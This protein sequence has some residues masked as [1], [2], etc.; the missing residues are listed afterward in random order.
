MSS[1]QAQHNQF[2]V[3]EFTKQSVPF[4]EAVVHFDD[5]LLDFSEVK[6]ADTVLD[7]A[8]GPGIVA[9]SFATR[10]KHV[11][12]IDLTPAMLE[13]ANKRQEKMQLENLSWQLGDVLPFRLRMR[14]F[15]WS[16]RGTR[17]I[18]FL[19][20]WRCARKCCAFVSRAEP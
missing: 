9:C 19:I 5:L 12:G 1:A 18:I 15:Q 3:D 8:C 16:S 13:L 2:I 10:A 4:A 11:T 20:H 14:R 7:V 17:F 6:V